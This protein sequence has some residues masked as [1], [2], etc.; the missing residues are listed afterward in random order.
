ME[1]FAGTSSKAQK[2]M[3]H[4]NVQWLELCNSEDAFL[5]AQSLSF[6]STVK[7]ELLRPCTM[8]QSQFKN[9]VS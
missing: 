1:I 7:I 2:S 8:L 3:L 4:N 9:A 5:A 6:S